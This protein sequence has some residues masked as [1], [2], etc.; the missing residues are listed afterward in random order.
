MLKPIDEK[1]KERNAVDGG[2]GRYEDMIYAAGKRGTGMEL[3]YY[4]PL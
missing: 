2:F 4:S 3:E 1:K